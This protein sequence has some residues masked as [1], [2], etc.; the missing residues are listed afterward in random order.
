MEPELILGIETARRM[1]WELLIINWVNRRSFFQ[2]AQFSP[3]NLTGQRHDFIQFKPVCLLL[4]CFRLLHESV[5]LP[6]QH[7]LEV[8]SVTSDL[9]AECEE[10]C[11][12]ALCRVF[13]MTYLKKSGGRNV[14]LI[15]E[16][17]E[18]WN[19][20]YSF[21]CSLFSA[22]CL[23]LIYHYK[24]KKIRLQQVFSSCVCVC[25]VQALQVFESHA[26]I[27]GPDEF[28]AF[29]LPYLRDIAR[30]VKEKLKETGKDVPMVRHTHTHT[31]TQEGSLRI[32]LLCPEYT[33]I[34]FI[35]S[36]GHHFT[37]NG[38]WRFLLWY[39][40][41]FFFTF[42]DRVCKGCSLRSGGSVWVSLWGGRAGLDHRPTIST[43]NKSVF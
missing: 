3:G 22:L 40:L 43:V 24:T 42:P 4:L 31:H 1:K 19:V 6:S 38:S 28:E 15:L 20:G 34:C 27:L 32:H 30:C 25:V 13:Q 18:Q 16:Y 36:R 7:P 17:Y 26:G 12:L 41:F 23:H 33:L 29:S 14:R 37:R 2:V 5:M 8:S 9:P 21:F 11:H 39:L 35:T 10:G